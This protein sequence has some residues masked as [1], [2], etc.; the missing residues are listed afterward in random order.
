M[1]ATLI[2][3]HLHSKSKKMPEPKYAV[4]H[5]EGS[6]I[7]LERTLDQRENSYR[8]FTKQ[9]FA[10]FSATLI[11]LLLFIFISATIGKWKRI[12]YLLPAHKILPQC[13]RILF[14]DELQIADVVDL[15]VPSVTVEWQNSV[16][17][18]DTEIEGDEMWNALMPRMY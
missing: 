4:L 12:N 5:D 17:Y 13:M 14:L 10:I 6:S 18:E 11:I 1:K 7:Q 3:L 16:K 8:F 9:R 2:L 15:L